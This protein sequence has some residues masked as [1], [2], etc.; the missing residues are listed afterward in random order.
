MNPRHSNPSNV[1]SIPLFLVH[2]L[3]RSRPRSQI[4]LFFISVQLVQGHFAKPLHLLWEPSSVKIP[5][6]PIYKHVVIMGDVIIAGEDCFHCFSVLALWSCLRRGR[7]CCRGMWLL[8]G[9][10]GL[11]SIDRW[12]DRWV[13]VRWR[14]WVIVRNKLVGL[15]IARGRNLSFWVYVYEMKCIFSSNRK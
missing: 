10:F 3:Y 15:G 11:N 12:R 1:C 14:N 6:K 13:I 5:N 2:N 7:W 9:D 8:W 4:T